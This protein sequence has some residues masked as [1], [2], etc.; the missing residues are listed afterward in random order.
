MALILPRNIAIAGL[1]AAALCHAAPLQAQDY[2]LPPTFGVISLSSDFLPDPNWV[3][4]LAGGSNRGSYT[5]AETGGN[6]AGYF[7]DAPDLRVHFTIGGGYPLSFYVDGEDDTVLLIN[8]PDGQWHCNDDSPLG[9]WGLDPALTFDTPLDG[10]YDIWVGTYSPIVD[11]YFPSASVYISELGAFFGMLERS[12]FGQDDRVVMDT[13]VAPWNM[14]GLVEMTEGS[15]TGALIGPATVL[16]AAHCFA[17]EGE[18]DTP[19]MTFRAGYTE[20]GEI[21]VS[22]VTGFHVPQGWRNGEQEGTD[23]A[24]MYLSEPLGD[25]LGWMDVGP[26]TDAEIAA[27]AA[28]NGP[29]IRQAGY[30]F[31]EPEY[32]TGNLDC[33]FLEVTVDNTLSHQC[34]TLSGDSGSPLFIADGNRYRIIGVESYTDPQPGA[35]FD[36]NLAMYAGGVVAEMQSLAS[37]GTGA[38]AGPARPQK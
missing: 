15:C 33:P 27:Y 14:I 16:T 5:D 10:Q 4:L 30:S 25:R 36:L 11:D 8:T 7:A 28:G 32:Q 19:P 37:G 20:G 17:N 38:P 31:D 9:P 18:S 13:T 35:E 3:G 23:F 6:C 29:D 21:A 22:G 24:F 1:A 12:F 2:S 34:D 26:L